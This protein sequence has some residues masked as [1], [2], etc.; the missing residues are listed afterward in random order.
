MDLHTP[1][2]A[3]TQPMTLDDFHDCPGPGC[4]RM[5]PLYVLACRRHWLQV[6]PGTKK[7]VN[8][9]RGEQLRAAHTQAI[10]EMRR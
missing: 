7:L 10:N 2:R 1:R 6:K 9:A 4:D 8:T 5:V 3:P